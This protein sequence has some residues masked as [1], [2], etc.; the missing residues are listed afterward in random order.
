ML[1]IKWDEEAAGVISDIKLFVK[2]VNVC[3]NQPNIDQ[4][5][6]IN[7]ETFE[8]EKFCIKLCANGF[9]VL[10]KRFNA[11]DSHD[12][13]KWYETPYALLAAISDSYFERFNQSLANRLKMIEN[14]SL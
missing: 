14:Q 4:M 7:L 9:G 6:L 2:D 3:Q 11:E 8:N 1:D 12:I 5:V 10:D 13:E